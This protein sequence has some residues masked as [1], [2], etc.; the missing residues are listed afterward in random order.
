[1]A[2]KE[3]IFYWEVIVVIQVPDFGLQD[4]KDSLDDGWDYVV[5]VD[6]VIVFQSLSHAQSDC[7][8]HH[9]HVL[10]T[11]I[12]RQPA[13]W[14]AKLA[15]RCEEVIRLQ[16][17]DGWLIEVRIGGWLNWR[18][19]ASQKGCYAQAAQ[20]W[21]LNT[22]LVFLPELQSFLHH[23]LGDHHVSHFVLRA[24]KVCTG[25]RKL[26][27]LNHFLELF[28]FS[29]VFLS[30]LFFAFFFLLKFA[31]FVEHVIVEASTED[32]MSVLS[33]GLDDSWISIFSNKVF[34]IVF[35]C[36]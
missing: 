1:M 16:V 27:L 34:T 4:A 11:N 31:N 3:L 25:C 35:Q 2:Q 22:S 33:V 10:F 12:G 20:L 6:L 32:G 13:S 26:E 5:L 23:G 17:Q 19:D 24:C 29:H 36:A 7:V 8:A 9:H 15:Q 30:T 21:V 14:G 18:V 28:S